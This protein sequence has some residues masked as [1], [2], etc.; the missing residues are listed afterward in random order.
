MLEPLERAILVAVDRACAGSYEHAGGE[1]VS[2]QLTAMGVRED[3]V[4]VMNCARHLMSSGLLNGI[5][6]FGNDLANGSYMLTMEGRA[7]VRNGD[8]MERTYDRARLVLISD[9]FREEYPH[10]YERWVAAEAL[11]NGHDAASHL[12]D[13][14]HRIREAMQEFATAMIE[15]HDPPDPDP[16]VPS[17][18]RRL[19]AVIAL[20]RPQLGDARRTMLEAL[21]TLWESCNALVQRQEHGS[22]KERERLTLADAHRLVWLTLFL[23]VEFAITLEEAQPDPPPPAFIES[24]R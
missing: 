2:K 14:G 20:Y 21:G 3:G 1:I 4:V 8:P 12:T 15:Q 7:L 6:G 18:E 10:A 9:A 13:V 24:G 19:G 16:H 5:V 11:L 22:Y 23:M 17:V